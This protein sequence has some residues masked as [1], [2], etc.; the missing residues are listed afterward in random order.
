M[1]MQQRDAIRLDE[2]PDDAAEDRRRAERG[3]DPRTRG[4]AL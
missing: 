4:G 3:D 1:W 2:R